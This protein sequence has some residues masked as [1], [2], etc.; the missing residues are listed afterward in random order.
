MLAQFAEALERN[1]AHI[2][3]GSEPNNLYE[4][5]RYIMQLGGKRLR[6]QLCLLSYSLYQ[7]S[8]QKAIK[9][10]IALEVFHN[11]SL[12]H[13]DLM[14]QAP[15]RRGQATVHQRWSANT[16]ILAGDVMLVKAYELFMDAQPLKDILIGFNKTAAQVCEGQQLD[17]NFE[18]EP[19]VSKD[20]YINMIGLKTSVLIAFALQLGGILAGVDKTEQQKLYDIGL[21][22][23]LGFQ[24]MDDILDVYGQPEKFGKQVGGDIL[25][26][27]KTWLLLDA[28]EGA[29]TS[30]QAK[31]HYW[32]QATAY[33]ADQK[34]AEVKAIYDA[35]GVPIHAQKL[36]N[37]YFELA[38]NGIGH[39]DGN[40]I[41]KEILTK[42]LLQLMQR[43]S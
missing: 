5:L 31:L 43:E 15:S 36:A 8:W 19:T 3:F 11:F 20:Q 1:I 6:P 37:S 40:V 22:A 7:N 24:I 12:I 33:P 29:N 17:M 38:L 35:I 23:G 13:D 16:A 2:T 21:N 39:L 25:A 30:Q 9:P 26:N 14:D 41:Q 28:L 4:P 42:F 32:Q 10:A 34:I 18:T 27:K